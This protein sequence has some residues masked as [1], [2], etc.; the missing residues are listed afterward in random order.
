MQAMRDLLELLVRRV[1]QASTRLQQDPPYAPTVEQGHI[2][3]N[4]GPFPFPHAEVRVRQT[5]IHLQGAHP[6]PIA[7]ATVDRQDRTEAR[8]RRA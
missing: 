6:Y 7:S 8:A 1:W 5:R 4:Q 3:Q 2:P